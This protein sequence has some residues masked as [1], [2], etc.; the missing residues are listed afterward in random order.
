MTVTDTAPAFFT[1]STTMKAQ[2][3]PTA[4]AIHRLE[5]LSMDE[6]TFTSGFWADHQ[7]VNASGIIP[8]CLAWEEKVGWIENFERAR[9]GTIAGHHAGLWFADSDVYKLIEAMAWE[10][11]RVG[12]TEQGRALE[13]EIQRLGTLIE[14]VQDEDGYLNTR[15]G[16]P[17]L[18]D[19]YTNFP[20]GHELYCT[21]HLIQ[22]AIARLRSGRTADDVIVRT[23]LRNADHVCATFGADGVEAVGGHPEVEV[24]LVELYRATGQRRYLDQAQ[25]FLDRRGHGLL[26]DFEW[27]LEYFQDDIPVREEA[28][29][30]GHAVRALYLMAGAVDAAMERGD[31]ELLDIVRAQYDR[32]L[33]RR[34]YLTGGMGSRHEGEAFGDDY[35]LPTDRCYCE[36][37]AGIGSIMVAWRLLLA[38]GDVRYADIIERT[39]YNVVAASPAAD[40]RSFFYANP[41]QVRVPGEEAM[42]GE[43]SSRS[44]TSLRA[45]WFE[46]S[47][48]P[49]NIARTLASL[50]GT[51]VTRSVESE[52]R[53]PEIQVHHLTSM[54]VRT[55][56]TTAPHGEEHDG[57]VAPLAFHLR[58][59]YPNDGRIGLV[60][61][62]APA[63]PV[64]LAVRIPSWASGAARL[65]GA[66]VESATGSGYAIIE[67]VLI[68]G[69]EHILELPMMPRVTYP[70]PRIDAVRGQI[71]IERGPLVLCAESVDLPEGVTTEDVELAPSAGPVLDADGR[72]TVEA[73]VVAP[74]ND[75]PYEPESSSGSGNTFALPLVPYYSWG[76]RGPVTMRVWLPQATS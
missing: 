53:V 40:G 45:S 9:T 47:C 17:G 57:A 72:V 41:L 34:T 25:I 71:A 1:A 67:G 51:S 65:D 19:R 12:D 33:A 42:T 2:V 38:T 59:D 15:Y 26:G 63:F 39:L 60:I 21:G 8:H 30:R 22:A 23:A 28:V 64:R 75:W 58:T 13:A 29:A 32:T 18:E 69:E 5:P 54:D 43:L 52:G 4:D 46:V 44:G 61:D 14:A 74:P 20:M 55:T 35:E 76:N 68:A 49:T 37:C 7:A 70:H 6:V 3:V 27:G 10:V 16:K 62:E 66:V 50:A 24:A 73:R 36:T 11:A 48:C 31:G 56:V